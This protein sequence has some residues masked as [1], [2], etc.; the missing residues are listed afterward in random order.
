MRG[1]SGTN[2][3]QGAP[4]RNRRKMGYDRRA[5]ST[6]LPPGL[7]SPVQR[8]PAVNTGIPAIGWH[9]AGSQP[10]AM[11]AQPGIIAGRHAFWRPCMRSSGIGRLVTIAR[12]LAGQDP[13]TVRGRL[14]W[15]STLTSFVPIPSATPCIDFVRLAHEYPHR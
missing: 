3:M 13:T 1:H 10:G 4:R 7:S 12:S 8:T 15:S 11:L 14:R 6:T 5:A 9:P 2:R